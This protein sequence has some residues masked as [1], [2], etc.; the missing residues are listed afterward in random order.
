[1]KEYEITFSTDLNETM[2]M[3]V[4][5]ESYIDAIEKIKKEFPSAFNFR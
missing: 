1:M 2:L 5:A 4:S 3:G